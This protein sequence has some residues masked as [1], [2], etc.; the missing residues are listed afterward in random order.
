MNKGH[1]L[2]ANISFLLMIKNILFFGIEY[3]V[4]I[5]KQGGP[6]DWGGSDIFAAYISKP[7]LSQ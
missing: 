2:E 1:I 7:N 4:K 3:F 5:I 6:L